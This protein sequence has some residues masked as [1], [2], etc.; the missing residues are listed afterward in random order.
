MVEVFSSDAERVLQRS[1]DV[2]LSE[3]GSRP[4]DLHGLYQISE[5]CS[6]ITSNNFKKVNFNLAGKHFRGILF[7]FFFLCYYLCRIC[8]SENQMFSKMTSINV[9]FKP[10][11]AVFTVHH[12]DLLL[13]TGSFAVS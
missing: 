4:E 1:V 13:Y 5:T 7:Y 3:S 2:N 10:A 11:S 9:C 8:A 12:H 6:F